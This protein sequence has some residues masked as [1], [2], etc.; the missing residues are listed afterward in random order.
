MVSGRSL[1]PEFEVGS[2]PVPR[3]LS[4]SALRNQ[5]PTNNRL[6]K[7]E[8]SEAHEVRNGNRHGE[9]GQRKKFLVASAK[10]TG[11][12]PATGFESDIH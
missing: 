8:L 5:R 3:L 11:W 2:A 1:G 4:G 6:V 10:A 9:H 7:A 12:P